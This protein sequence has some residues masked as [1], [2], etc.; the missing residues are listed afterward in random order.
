M[1]SFSG[2]WAYTFFCNAPGCLFGEVFFNIA[3]F[4]NLIFSLKKEIKERKTCIT[5]NDVDILKPMT[6][7]AISWCLSKSS[8]TTFAV[9][10]SKI[11]LILCQGWLFFT[12]RNKKILCM[13]V[14]FTAKHTFHLGNYMPSVSA[15]ED[16]ISILL[17]HTIF[18]RIFYWP[19]N[20]S[21]FSPVFAIA[22]VQNF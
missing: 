20:T 15:E 21:S 11:S 2:I 7:I 8:H 4:Q 13:A 10:L 1:S 9:L 14:V 12:W 6:S 3:V 5:Y 17:N 16:K 22:Y 18:A 19:C